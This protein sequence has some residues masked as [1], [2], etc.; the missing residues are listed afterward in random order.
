MADNCFQVWRRSANEFVQ[1]CWQLAA[2]SFQFVFG[3]FTH[4]TL[5]DS[6]LFLSLFPCFCGLRSYPLLGSLLA[7]SFTFSLILF[8]L[9]SLS[10]PH[11][12]V[13]LLFYVFNF[14]RFVRFGLARCTP[15]TEDFSVS[16]WLFAENS[17][18]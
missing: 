8:T 1:F 18:P 15:T 6:L 13:W 16:L 4:G 5:S 2:S 14:W 10:A 7:L 11:S 3:F 9:S 12:L 17:L